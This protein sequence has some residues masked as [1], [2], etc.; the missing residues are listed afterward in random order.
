[1]SKRMSDSPI[2]MFEPPVLVPLR[3]TNANDEI[4]P[5]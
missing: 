4:G 5:A 3:Y 1:M 2:R